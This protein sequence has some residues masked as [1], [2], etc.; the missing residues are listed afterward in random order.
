MCATSKKPWS[1]ST[2]SWDPQENWRCKHT[3]I[4]PQGSHL[5]PTDAQR[6]EM[7]CPFH[8]ILYL[9][10]KTIWFELNHFLFGL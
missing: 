3:W 4:T 10:C 9:I 2:F 6:H 8:C 1:H 5:A 7:M